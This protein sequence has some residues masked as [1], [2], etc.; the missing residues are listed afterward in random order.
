VS[1]L[2]F[3]VGALAIG[4]FRLGLGLA[5]LQTL[6]FFTLVCGN[7]ATTYAV[8]ARRRIWAVPRPS[9]WVAL[10]SGA[11]VLIASVL[12]GCGW[13]MMP[14][15]LWVLATVLAGAVVFAFAVDLGKVSIFNRLRIA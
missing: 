1:E 5:A 13:L 2:A 14:L 9:R 15:P 4:H 8:R 12:A 3:C 10:S 6:A 7:Q 11:D